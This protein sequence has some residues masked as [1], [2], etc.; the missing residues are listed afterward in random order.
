[1]DADVTEAVTLS[2]KIGGT[3]ICLGC[4]AGGAEL[5][6]LMSGTAES[7]VTV[8]ILVVSRSM[9]VASAVTLNVSKRD[10]AEVPPTRICRV[11][12]SIERATLRTY[13][14]KALVDKA[15]RNCPAPHASSFTIL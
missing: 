13:I 10:G 8:S 14:R 2:A 3:G 7:S 5:G 9:S 6:G 15:R 1:M 4:S 11:H 12:S